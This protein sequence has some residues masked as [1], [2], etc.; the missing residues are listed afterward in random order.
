MTQTAM[1]CH[2]LQRISPALKIEVR[3]ICTAGDLLKDAPLDEIGGKGVFVK[4]IEKALLT[5]EIDLAA[6]VKFVTAHEDPEK[7]SGFLDW[8]NLAAETGTLI[9]L[10][11]GPFGAGNK[12]TP[13][14]K[15][16]FFV[17]MITC[18]I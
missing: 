14:K 18:S 12:S 4:D 7:I 2:M 13:M 17:M 11:D 16:S 15:N 8:K 6:S 3:K 10:L 1:V 9:F 5:D